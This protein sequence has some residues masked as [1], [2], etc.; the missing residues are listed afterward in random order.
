MK[1]IGFPA[2]GRLAKAGACFCATLI[3]QGCASPL[4]FQLVDA[5]AR[6]A[7]GILYPGDGHI[8]ANVD[9]V[10]FSGF[11]IFASG[12]AVSQTFGGRWGLPRETETT[13]ESNSARAHLAA[14]DG[15]SLDCQFLLQGRRALGECRTPQGTTFQL[16]AGEK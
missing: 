13:Y 10:V 14:A 4:P 6:V 5:H 7:Q 15:R 16:I 8:E 1:R 2:A 12:S 3:V 11:F 9:G